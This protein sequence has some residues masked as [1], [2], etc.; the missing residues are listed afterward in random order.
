MDALRAC[1]FDLLRLQL[2]HALLQA[3]DPGLPLRGLVRERVTLPLL[4]RLLALL[5]QLL[6]LLRALLNSIRR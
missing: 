3:I 5:D 1:A 4:R 6:M 2:L